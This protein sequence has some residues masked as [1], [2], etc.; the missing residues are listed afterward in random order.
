[1]E[2]ITVK[3]KIK[4]LAIVGR[5]QKIVFKTLDM[6]S[7]QVGQLDKLIRNNKDEHVK[8]AI[9]PGKE[10]LDIPAIESDV[11]LVAMDCTGKGQNLKVSG[12]HAPSEQIKQ[13]KDY[14]ESESEIV[15]QIEQTQEKMIDETPTEE[16]TESS[17]QES[18]D[19]EEGFDDNEPGQSLV[20]GHE[21]KVYEVN[22]SGNITNPEVITVKLPKNY[23]TMIAMSFGRSNDNWYFGYDLNIGNNG[24]GVPCGLDGGENIHQ[25]I[26][27][28]KAKIFEFIDKQKTYKYARQAK[29]KIE[30]AIEDWKFENT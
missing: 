7:R 4:L 28:A 6:T 15:L 30:K 25:A 2:K 5:Q 24:I 14:I 13:L 23:G 3:T 22:E 21:S 19:S 26:E 20:S 29:K 17:S 11:M 18:E 8:L 9:L 16:N 10:F 27:T 1:M 12:F